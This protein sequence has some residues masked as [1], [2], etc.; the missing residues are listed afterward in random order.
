M[1][2]KKHASE[3]KC[4]ICGI[5]ILDAKSGNRRYCAA[6]FIEVNRI[7]NRENKRRRRLEGRVEKQDEWF[8]L[9]SGPETMS[10]LI[11][12]SFSALQISFGLEPGSFWVDQG[13]V[14]SKN[15]NMFTVSGR[16]MV[17]Q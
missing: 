6:C 16:R 15:G 13:A 8:T 3:C 17:C 11:G 5:P 2:T 12:N 1:T 4:E 7:R 10:D 9:V 14:F